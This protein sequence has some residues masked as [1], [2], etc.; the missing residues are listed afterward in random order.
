MKTSISSKQKDDKQRVGIVNATVVVVV[1][2][3]RV[4]MWAATDGVNHLVGMG[5]C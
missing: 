3:R 1:F 5:A 4:E 2:G